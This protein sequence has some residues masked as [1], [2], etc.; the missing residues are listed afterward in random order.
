MLKLSDKVGVPQKD[1]PVEQP[2][3]LSHLDVQY[4]F[5]EIVEQRFCLGCLVPEYVRPGQFEELSDAL[6]RQD[7]PRKK[8]LLT[9]VRKESRVNDFKNIPQVVDLVW[10]RIRRGEDEAFAREVIQ[11][12]LLL[13][14]LGVVHNYLQEWYLLEDLFCIAL[15]H[16]GCRDE[17]FELEKLTSLREL[18]FYCDIFFEEHPL[19]QLNAQR[20][21]KIILFYL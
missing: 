3:G 10:D 16:F 6:D 21:L 15:Y 17:H 13:R 12:L 20:C 19:P 8:M 2:L 1:L 7:L 11:S 14:V 4:N 9:F 18:A 5:I